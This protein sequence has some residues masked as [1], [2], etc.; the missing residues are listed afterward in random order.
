LQ[1]AQSSALPTI[2]VSGPKRASGLLS[3][4]SA[5]LNSLTAPVPASHSVCMPLGS[6]GSLNSST[7]H[8]SAIHSVCMPLG[9]SS[10]LA[11]TVNLENE[12][13]QRPLPSPASLQPVSTL[14]ASAPA[15]TRN[16]PPL[17]RK[18]PSPRRQNKPLSPQRRELSR[19]ILNLKIFWKT[20]SHVLP[21]SL[22]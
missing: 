15:C 8:V 20:C 5:S 17:P 7:A 18:C 4:R 21:A 22:D 19:P 2:Q 6:S 10:S 9:R 12:A 16:K 11:C 14:T 3:G 1:S 13:L